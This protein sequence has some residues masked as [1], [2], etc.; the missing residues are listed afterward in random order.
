MLPPSNV[1]SHQN[2]SEDPHAADMISITT[3]RLSIIFSHYTLA[4]QQPN[5]DLENDYASGFALKTLAL[6]F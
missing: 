6:L 2:L 3:L 4:Y 1:S 5:P